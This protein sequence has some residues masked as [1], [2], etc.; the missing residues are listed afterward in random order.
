MLIFRCQKC[1][2]NLRIPLKYGIGYHPLKH[3]CRVFDKCLSF[4]DFSMICTTQCAH[5][6]HCKSI[7]KWTFSATVGRC[8]CRS[9]KSFTSVDQLCL[10]FFRH[11][12]L[13][14]HLELLMIGKPKGFIR[15]RQKVMTRLVTLVM[16]SR[17]S[18]V[19]FWVH[20]HR[21]TKAKQILSEI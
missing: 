16:L 4:L 10:Q 14:S 17:C 3:G 11:L 21:K 5:G 15:V 7:H 9:I 19:T 20:E 6:T 2:A 1:P 8:T 18:E 12:I 13:L